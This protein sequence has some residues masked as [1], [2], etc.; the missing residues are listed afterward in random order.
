MVLD[1]A[2]ESQVQPSLQPPASGPGWV[3]GALQEG[4]RNLHNFTSKLEDSRDTEQYDRNSSGVWTY[5]LPVGTTTVAVG[6]GAVEVVSV[7]PAHEQAEAKRADAIPLAVHA[8][9][10]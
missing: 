9:L 5:E 3:P 4:P 1:P 8:V 10:A 2:R 7:T 6:T